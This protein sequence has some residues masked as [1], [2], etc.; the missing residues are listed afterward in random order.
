M[1]IFGRIRSYHQ[2]QDGDSNS[3]DSPVGVGNTSPRCPMRRYAGA[4][5]VVRRRRLLARLVIAVI[6]M[7]KE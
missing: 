7:F 1:G 2:R 3:S 6:R 4:W 5:R